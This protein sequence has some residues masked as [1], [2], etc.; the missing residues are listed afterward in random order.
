[1][2]ALRNEQ[3][4]ECDELQRQHR[5]LLEKYQLEFKSLHSKETEM[6]QSYDNSLQLCESELEALLEKGCA[7]TCTD[8]LTE[9][10]PLIEV[11]QKRQ[12]AETRYQIGIDSLRDKRRYSEHLFENAVEALRKASEDCDVKYEN[13]FEAGSRAIKTA[14]ARG[15]QHQ[16]KVEMIQRLK[17]KYA[18]DV[19][20]LIDQLVD[21]FNSE[22][23][24]EYGDAPGLYTTQESNDNEYPCCRLHKLG[25]IHGR[26]VSTRRR[27]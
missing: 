11:H 18:E 7:A 2:Q 20:T 23:D 16:Q 12:I 9:M 10:H 13:M 27:L 1:M 21:T 24:T 8:E 4:C 17:R 22:Y 6:R 26:H 5:A 19:K 25:R 3:Q 14:A 15:K